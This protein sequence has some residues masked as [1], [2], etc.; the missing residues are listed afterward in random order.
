VVAAGAAQLHGTTPVLVDLDVALL[1]PAE[2]LVSAEPSRSV[3]A[4]GR[5]HQG[6]APPALAA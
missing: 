4:L 3:S 1:A 2:L 5:P 6:R